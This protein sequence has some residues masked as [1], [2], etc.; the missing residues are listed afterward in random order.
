MPF[1]KHVIIAAA[2]MGNRLGKGIP[3]SLVEVN[4]RK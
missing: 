2:G 3:K 1:V 4:N